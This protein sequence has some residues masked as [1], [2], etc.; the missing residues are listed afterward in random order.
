MFSTEFNLTAYKQ[1]IGKFL[2]AEYTIGKFSEK[3]SKEQTLLIRHDVDFDCMLALDMARFEY[4]MGVKSTYFFLISSAAYNPFSGSVRKCIEN[5]R[6]F[7]H[8]ISLHFDPEIYL[9]VEKGLLEELDIFERA[10]SE[11]PKVISFHRPNNFFVNHQDT[12]AGVEHTYQPKFTK[13]IAYLADSQGQWRFGH[14]LKSNAFK[15][16]ASLH[17]LIH[18]LWW[19]LPGKTPE[20]KLKV[21]FQ[22]QVARIKSHDAANCKPFINILNE[23]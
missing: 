3:F 7:G 22:K 8:E 12:I 15:N 6:E 10:F 1:L 5:I 23:L 21:L 2:Q 18:P 16:N 9:D 13:E 17:L 20:E 11:R 19:T 4:Q 14:P